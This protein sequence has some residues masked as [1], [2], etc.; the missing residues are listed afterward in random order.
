MIRIIL[1]PSKLISIIIKRGFHMN[2]AIQKVQFQLEEQLP[3]V[4][5]WRRYLHQHPELSFKEKKHHN[6]S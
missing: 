2:E 1:K 6:L 4:I 3:E 5:E